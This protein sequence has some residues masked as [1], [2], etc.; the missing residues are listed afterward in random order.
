MSGQRVTE[1]EDPIPKTQKQPGLRAMGGEASTYKSIKIETTS[2][3]CPYHISEFLDL[4]RQNLIFFNKPEAESN[5]SHI[6]FLSPVCTSKLS[7]QPNPG[8]SD[9]GLKEDLVPIFLKSGVGALPGTN[10]LMTC[11]SCLLVLPPRYLSRHPWLFFWP[12]VARF[13]WPHLVVT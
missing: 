5:N 7:A 6:G 1:D 9:T 10:W 13:F 4:P 11:S 3:P 2:K 12:A 8:G